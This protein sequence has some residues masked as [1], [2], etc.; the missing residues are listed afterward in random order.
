[1]TT[2]TYDQFMV[3]DPTESYAFKIGLFLDRWVAK[4]R[5]RILVELAHLLFLKFY[6][7]LQHF[8]RTIQ[9]EEEQSRTEAQHKVLWDRKSRV[10]EKTAELI[11][12]LDA[13]G[14]VTYRGRDLVD[15]IVGKDR[16][17]ELKLLVDAV[18]FEQRG[19]EIL[20]RTRKDFLTAF[21]KRQLTKSQRLALLEKHRE[22]SEFLSGKI[23]SS[24]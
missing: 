11:A 20:A 7:D 17:E 23:P 8:L 13:I 1:M 3:S 18:R 22:L 15:Y 4:V 16:V 14:R 9:S 21:G 10:A 19:E 12:Q 6:D 24:S 5:T 2:T